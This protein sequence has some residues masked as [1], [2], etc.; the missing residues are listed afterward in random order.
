LSPEYLFDNFLEV[1]KMPVDIE[2]ERGVRGFNIVR[3]ECPNCNAQLIFKI[4]K[5]EIHDVGGDGL[6]YPEENVVRCKVCMSTFKY[7][8][9]NTDESNKQN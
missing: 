3:K 8:T 5:N 7:K 2:L 6:F 1:I 9:K 4:H